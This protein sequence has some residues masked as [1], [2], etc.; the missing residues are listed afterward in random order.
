MVNRVQY[1]NVRSKVDC[2]YKTSTGLQHMVFEGNPGTGKTTVARLLGKIYHSFGLLKKGHLVE[3]SRSDLVAGFV[4][5]TALKTKEKIRDA[6]DGVLFVDEAYSLYQGYGSDFGHEAIDT[7]VKAMEDYRDR[8]VVIAAGYPLQMTD[9]IASNPGL[10][11]RF[12]IKVHFP[13]F[14]TLELGEILMNFAQREKYILTHEVLE[15]ACRY[16]EYTRQLEEY[17]GNARSVRNLFEEMKGRLAAR[18][19]NTITLEGKSAPDPDE[20]V[21]FSL[22]DIPILA[23]QKIPANVT[24]PFQSNA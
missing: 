11:S 3:V 16:L 20:M 10:S 21:R 13:D 7:L 9:F 14:D 17:F 1:E 2:D 18:I 8:L 5:Q 24:S 4:G 19:M 12:A 6:L 15:G 22:D 23:F